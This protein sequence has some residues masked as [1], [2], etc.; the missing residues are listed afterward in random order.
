MGF[1]AS[2]YGLNGNL[3]ETVY[4]QQPP[5]FIRPGEEHL[6]CQLHKAIYGLRQSSRAWHE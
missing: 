3:T 4:L 2:T 5:G 6:V 1:W